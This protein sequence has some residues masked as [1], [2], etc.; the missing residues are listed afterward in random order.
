[1][2][3]WLGEEVSKWVSEIQDP[4]SEGPK[5]RDTENPSPAHQTCNPK[6]RTSESQENQNRKTEHLIPT[7]RKPEKTADTKFHEKQQLIRH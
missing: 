7:I 1:M 2:S 6:N 4:K 3:K 5:N